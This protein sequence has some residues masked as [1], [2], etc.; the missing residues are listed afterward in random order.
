MLLAMPLL[1]FE[2][3]LHAFLYTPHSSD[4]AF[5]MM[6]DMMPLICCRLAIIFTAPYAAD[7]TAPYAAHFAMLSPPCIRHALF[8]G[9]AATLLP[10]DLIFAPHSASAAIDDMPFYAAMPTIF[11]FATPTRDI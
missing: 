2:F 1:C 10:A 6:I 7:V 11:V 9:A 8:A 3:L 5:A 4:A